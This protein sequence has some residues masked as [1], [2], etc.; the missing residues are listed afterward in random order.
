M[1]DDGV[2]CGREYLPLKRILNCDN[3]NHSAEK[4]NISLV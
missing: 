1:C 3:N 4:Y 2:A